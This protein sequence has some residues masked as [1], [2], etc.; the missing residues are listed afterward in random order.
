MV[1]SHPCQPVAALGL[2]QRSV[3]EMR[4]REEVAT[5]L[6]LVRAGLNDY[7]IARQT[8]IPRGTVRVWRVGRVPN[9][10]RAPG[11]GRIGRP[12]A[13]R[14]GQPLALPQDVAG[15]PGDLR[16]GV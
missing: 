5:V 2:A 15:H 14:G 4:T 16:V 13:V 7:E 6:E 1:L 8:G 11:D 12:C 10:E 3:A 9:F